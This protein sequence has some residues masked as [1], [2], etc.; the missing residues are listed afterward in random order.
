MQVERGHQIHSLCS[1]VHLF[2]DVKHRH[3]GTGLFVCQTHHRP[4]L[5]GTFWET[6][7]Q[8]VVCHYCCECEWHIELRTSFPHLSGCMQHLFVVSFLFPGVNA[9]F[10]HRHNIRWLPVGAHLRLGRTENSSG[11]VTHTT[12]ELLLENVWFFICLNHNNNNKNTMPKKKP[13]CMHHWPLRV[14]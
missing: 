1:Y 3:A 7:K 11:W 5:C 6:N 8:T 13:P 10:L 4:L 2:E 12:D 9:H 14:S